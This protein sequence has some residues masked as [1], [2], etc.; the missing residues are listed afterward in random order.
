MHKDMCGKLNACSLACTFLRFTQN[1]SAYHLV[2]W[3]SYHLIELHNVV[4]NEGGPTHHHVI[5]ILDYD[6]DGNPSIPSQTNPATAA[7]PV[8]QTT[9]TI[10]ASS[11]P[12]PS[13]TISHPRCTTY[14][15]VCNNN[16]CYTALPYSPWQTDCA[17]ANVAHTTNSEDPWSYEKAIV[18]P[19]TA[20]WLMAC[21][22]EKHT[23]LE[24]DI[25]NVAL[26][27]KDGKVIGS[28]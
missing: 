20:K 22:L 8:T 1:K 6:G 4:L 19:D 25:Y 21:K 18:C 16:P 15:L 23:F 10:L 2:H 28:K 3:P 27:L 26:R 24:M 9:N 12:T 5:I 13:I 7:P 17:T 11:A 14:T